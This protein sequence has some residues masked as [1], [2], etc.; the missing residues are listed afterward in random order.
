MWQRCSRHPRQG[1]QVRCDVMLCPKTFGGVP[2]W[3]RSSCAG[4][5]LS[6][7]LHS[8][9]PSLMSLCVFVIVFFFIISLRTLIATD[10]HTAV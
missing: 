10:T 8:V 1:Q 3:G 2:Q 4:S 7:P 9:S 5:L 6:S